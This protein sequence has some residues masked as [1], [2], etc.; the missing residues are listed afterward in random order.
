[1]KSKRMRLALMLIAVSLVF[2]LIACQ[3]TPTTTG[4]GTTTTKAATTTTGSG[5]STTAAEEDPV[6][7]SIW[8]AVGRF[9]LEDRRDKIPFEEDIGFLEERFNIKLNYTT[10]PSEQARDQLGIMLATNSMTDIISMQGSFD[11]FLIRPDQMFAD[12]QIIDLKSIEES[13]PTFM[14]IVDD[15]PVIMKNVMD[16]EDHILYFGMPI[17]EAEVGMSGGLMIRKDWLDMYDLD[18]PQSIDDFLTALRAFRDNDPNGNSTADE[19]PFCG[20]QG[21]LQVIGNLIGVQETFSMVGG[22]GGYVV[23]GPFEED[24][25]KK[26]LELIHTM[27]SEK[28]IN[29]NYYNF[30][31]SMRNTW[32]AEDRVGAALTGLGNLDNWN[33][34][35]ADHPTFLMWPFNNPMQE[36][37]N[38]YFDRTDLSKAMRHDVT[39]ISSNAARPDKCG[40]FLDYFYT[41]EGHMLTTFG[42][43]GL[44]YEMNGDFPVY[45]DLILKNPDDLGVGD[46]QGKY[47][48]IPGVRTYEDLRVWAQLSLTTPGSRQAAMRTWTDTFTENTNTPIPP[49]MMSE[50]DADEYADI[51]ADL[52]TYILESVA[53]FTTGEWVIDEQFD[54]FVAQCKVLGAERAL[55]LQDKAIK[56]WQNRGGVPYE[57]TLGRAQIDW[58]KIPLKTEKGIELMD[59]DL[60]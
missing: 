18:I 43:E 12:G 35:M 45:T 17:F 33:N 51:M 14:G 8:Y 34:L 31:F 26:R 27:A 28:L 7:V 30:D 20:N 54:A 32:V 15:N 46:A 47:L 50:V 5:T 53:K 56:N 41:E 16:D 58:S 10:A 59:P 21:S 2:S 4:S 29:E 19:V 40:E 13:I 23:F 44:T 39:M 6:D 57:Y 24:L 37:G 60:R 3:Q 36:D 49:A 52:Q 25:Y 11:T 9:T 38:R 42:V 1:M 48:G 55:E 22:S